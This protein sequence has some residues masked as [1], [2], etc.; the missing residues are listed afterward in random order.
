MCLEDYAARSCCYLKLSATTHGVID[1]HSY[2]P[3]VTLDSDLW[4]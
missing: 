1:A 3:H 2:N 4:M